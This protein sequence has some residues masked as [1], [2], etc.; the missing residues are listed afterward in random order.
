MMRTGGGCDD[1][2]APR[3]HPRDDAAKV[4]TLGMK[5]PA[6]ASVEKRVD[7]LLDAAVG[8]DHDGGT[9]AGAGA[10]KLLEAFL[11]KVFWS[12]L[13]GASK[14]PVLDAPNDHLG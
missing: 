10:L 6:L 5:R 12:S 4:S 14:P 13:N 1:G 2:W 11:A 9:D 8:V 3:I 7:R